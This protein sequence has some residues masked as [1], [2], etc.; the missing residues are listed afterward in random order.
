MTALRWVL[1]GGTHPGD[2]GYLPLM[3]D[4]EDPRAAVAQLNSWLPLWRPFGEGEWVKRGQVITYP[5]DPPLHPRAVAMLRDEL[6]V[7]YDHDLLLIEQL[8]GSFEVARMD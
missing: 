8:D 6:L 2:L 7:F 1:Y 4:D 5:G 3:L